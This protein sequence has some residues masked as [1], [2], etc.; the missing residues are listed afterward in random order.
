MCLSRE[1]VI[2]SDTVSPELPRNTCL[3]TPY[4]PPLQDSVM[5]SQE[6]A[7]DDKDDAGLP[8]EDTDGSRGRFLPAGGAPAL[9][10]GSP[11]GRPFCPQILSSSHLLSEGQY[12]QPGPLT[13]GAGA[14]LGSSDIPGQRRQGG[15]AFPGRTHVR[16][17]LPW[18]SRRAFSSALTLGVL[19]K[20]CCGSNRSQALPRVG[21]RRG[22]S[23]WESLLA[24][25]FLS[26]CGILWGFC[27]GGE[28]LF[29]VVL[30]FF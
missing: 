17:W 5:P 24:R 7:V 27:G 16:E 30:L 20:T 1:V 19:E 12:W 29:N 15:V 28:T 21:C 9:Y 8:S 18:G 22:W 23:P 6:P 4:C 14:S 25:W 26:F 11:A 13:V 3:V 2:E 10:P